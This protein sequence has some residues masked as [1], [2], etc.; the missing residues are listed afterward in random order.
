VDRSA[1]KKR[2]RASL[3]NSECGPTDRAS[4]TGSAGVPSGQSSTVAIQL[5]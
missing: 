3:T 4:T 2:L 5:Q 1:R